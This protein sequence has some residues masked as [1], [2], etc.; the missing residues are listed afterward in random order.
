MGQA[1][2]VN[3]DNVTWL[4]AAQDFLDT[5]DFPKDLVLDV[6]RAPTSREMDPS[7]EEKGHPVVRCRRGDITVCVGL[8]DFDAPTVIYVYLHTPEDGHHTGK[9][10]G[11]ASGG[12]SK[13]PKSPE[14][15][16]GWLQSE[17]CRIEH[18]GRGHYNVYLEGVLVGGVG[19]TIKA[20]AVMNDY[21]FMRR[22]LAAVRARLELEKARDERRQAD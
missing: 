1:R 5:Y 10:P 2:K 22:R 7:S 14:Q 15:L 20:Q 4:D 3:L 8:R 11:F 13:T 12:S 16:R 19:S 21:S 17:G 6:V 18:N 9:A